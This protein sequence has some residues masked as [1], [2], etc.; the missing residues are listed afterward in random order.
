MKSVQ[1]LALV[2]AL[3]GSTAAFSPIQ[4]QAVSNTALFNGLGAGGMADT[5]DPDELDHEDSRKSISAA[6]SFEEYLKSRDGGAAAVS[7]ST[8][9]TSSGMDVSGNAWKPDSEKMG[10]S[11]VSVYT[12]L[13]NSGKNQGLS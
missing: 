13:E 6:P 4:Q 7:A 11:T 10:V 9:V 8:G 12:V 2:A 5:R 1:S 3:A